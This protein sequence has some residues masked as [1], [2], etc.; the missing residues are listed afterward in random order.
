MRL[1]Y[2]LG[3]EAKEES[4]LQARKEDAYVL[5]KALH[6]PPIATTKGQ[7]KTAI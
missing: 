7:D 5:M 6:Q 2:F 1:Q 4:R 3:S